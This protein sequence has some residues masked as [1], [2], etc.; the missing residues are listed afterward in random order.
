MQL[1]SSS[2]NVASCTFT[3]Q[4]SLHQTAKVQEKCSKSQLF[5]QKNMNQS[6]RR[7]LLR[8]TRSLSQKKKSRQLRMQTKRLLKIKK[9]RMKLRAKNQ[10]RIRKRK[11]MD[12]EKKICSTLNLFPLRSRSLTTRKIC[13]DVLLT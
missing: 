4:S 5:C 9:R 3:L 1:T 11:L 2:N 12:Q 7:S 6:R 10:R 8:T 13:L